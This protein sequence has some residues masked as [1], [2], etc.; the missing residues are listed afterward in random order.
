LLAALEGRFV[1]V[2]NDAE[3]TPAELASLLAGLGL[4]VPPER[5]VLAGAVTLDLIAREAPGAAIMLLGSPT[6]EAYARAAGLCVRSERP[7]LV[8]VARDRQFT[9]AKLALAANAVRCGAKLVLTNPDRTHPGP[10][11]DVV[12]ETGALASAVQACTGPVAHR[13]IGKPEPALFEAGLAILGVAA[14]EAVM[15][16]DNPETDGLGAKRAGI[17]FAPVQ[18]GRLAPILSALGQACDGED[19]AVALASA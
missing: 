14:G 18:A 10:K 8:V 11:G 3:H 12:P 4:A 19:A 15:I 17:A 5:L 13:V 7:D 16:G 2:S 6:L 9:Y 1:V